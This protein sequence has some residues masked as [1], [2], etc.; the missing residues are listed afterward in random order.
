LC[1]DGWVLMKGKCLTKNQSNK[2]RLLSDTN[3]LRKLQSK[4][5]KEDED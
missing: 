4:K 3:N 2:M 1:E 5:P